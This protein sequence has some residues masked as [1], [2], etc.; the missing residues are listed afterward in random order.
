MSVKYTRAQLKAMRKLELKKQLEYNIQ[1]IK[2]KLSDNI[3]NTAVTSNNGFGATVANSDNI[4][5]DFKSSEI[6]YEYDINNNKKNNVELHKELDFSRILI[7][8]KNCETSFQKKVNELLIRINNRDF[9]SEKDTQDYNRLMSYITE[10]LNDTLLTD[11]DKLLYLEKRI[12]IFLQLHD[13]IA[14]ENSTNL[15][16]IIFEYHALCKL[17]DITPVEKNAQRMIKESIKLKEALQTRMQDEYIL[18]TLNDIM[19]DLGCNLKQESILNNTAGQLFSINGNLLCDVFMGTEHGNILFEAVAHSKNDLSV[20]K[21]QMQES[22]GSVCEMYKEIASLAAKK[23]VILNDIYN[24][25][26]N[27]SNIHVIEDLKQEDNKNTRRKK[28][29]AKTMQME[30]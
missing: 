20:S 27:E 9:K 29:Q 15:H 19:N 14:K 4:N 11:D 30:E 5:D 10:T 2:K 17:A 21:K 8:C 26:V 25:E 7:N 28:T 23:D 13:N 3:K 18:N 24:Y 1:E 16:D 6:K 22:A 12:N